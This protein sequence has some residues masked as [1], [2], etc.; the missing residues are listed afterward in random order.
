MRKVDSFRLIFIDLNVP[1]LFR[2]H[3]CTERSCS[4]V[5]CSLVL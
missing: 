5:T 4:G 1:P 3:L 2:S